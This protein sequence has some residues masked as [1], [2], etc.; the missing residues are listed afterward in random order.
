M[1]ELQKFV[2]GSIFAI[3]AA[4]AYTTWTQNSQQGEDET[5]EPDATDEVFTMPFISPGQNIDDLS[6]ILPDYGKVVFDNNTAPGVAAEAAV[7]AEKYRI[8]QLVSDYREKAKNPQ[9][10]SSQWED[11][12]KNTTNSAGLIPN[13]DIAVSPENALQLKQLYYGYGEQRY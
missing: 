11:S 2:F 8:Y 13:P 6:S 3:F 9:F 1:I 5:E 4:V 10:P 12:N 7:E